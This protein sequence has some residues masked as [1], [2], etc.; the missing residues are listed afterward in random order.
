MKPSLGKSLLYQFDSLIDSLIT[1]HNE[2][3]FSKENDI[4][5]A[6]FGLRDKNFITN[7]TIIKYEFSL[8]EVKGLILGKTPNECVTNLFAF[9]ECMDDACYHLVY[10][11][12][13]V[14]TESNITYNDCIDIFADNKSTPTDLLQKIWNDYS[15]NQ[16]YAEILAKNIINH[17]NLSP[18]LKEEVRTLLVLAA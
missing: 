11:M 14:D 5:W 2:E 18:E 1:A 8:V 16:Y 15:K 12:R 4:Y 7:H 10:D 9:N 13:Y 17:P 6:C 3:N